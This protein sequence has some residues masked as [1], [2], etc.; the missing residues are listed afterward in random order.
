MRQLFFLLFF[1][2][3]LSCSSSQQLTGVAYKGYSIQPTAGVDSSLYKMIGP[4]RDIINRTMDE[5]LAENEVDLLK[6]IPDSRLGNFLADAYLWSAKEKLD[7]EAE[8]AFMNHGGVRVNRIGKG[9]VTR[10]NIYE[11][12][13]FDNLLVVAEVKGSLLQQYLDRLAAEGGGGGVAGISMKIRDKKAVEVLVNGKPLDPERTYKMVNSDYTLDSG[14]G[15]QEFKTLK[16][17]RSGYLMRDAIID[18]CK[19]LQSSGKKITVESP[20][21]ISK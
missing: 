12:M 11:V 3:L 14:S 20:M 10:R 8:M 9:Q 4:Y 13:P 7:K 5:V 21:R 1:V 2:S 17:Q 19:H 15:I 6:E 18:Y 16:Q